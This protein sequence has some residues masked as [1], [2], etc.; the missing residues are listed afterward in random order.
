MHNTNMH[1]RPACSFSPNLYA[2]RVT[3]RHPNELPNRQLA[4]WQSFDAKF[5]T[6]SMSFITIRS[7]KSI[8]PNTVECIRKMLSFGHNK[9][10]GFSR[11]ELYFMLMCLSFDFLTVNAKRRHSLAVTIHNAR[12]SY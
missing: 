12:N 5:K 11:C 2:F 1:L 4:R 8:G 6:E 10:C 7:L 3:W 9:S